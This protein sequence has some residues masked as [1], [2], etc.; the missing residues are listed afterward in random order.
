MG[1]LFWLFMDS[2]LTQRILLLIFCQVIAK[3]SIFLILSIVFKAQEHFD[4]A[5]YEIFSKEYTV[6][7]LS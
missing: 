5:Q 3:K 1:A 6:S 2:F 7:I 4:F